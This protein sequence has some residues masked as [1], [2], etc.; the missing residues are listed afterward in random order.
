PVKAAMCIARDGKVGKDEMREFKPPRFQRES[1]DLV[2][3]EYRYI[4][5]KKFWN[6]L[7]SYDSAVGLLMP[8]S[9]IDG[10]SVKL[11]RERAFVRLSLD[12]TNLLDKHNLGKSI[13]DLV[14][15]RDK[16]M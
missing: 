10:T 6:W 1:Q 12:L 13:D 3:F 4:S 9:D 14:I 16:F 5:G 15:L 11:A 2:G 8:I 7:T